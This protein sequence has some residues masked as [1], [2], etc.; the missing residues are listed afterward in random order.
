M[1]H[2]FFFNDNPVWS[3]GVGELFESPEASAATLQRTY[4][5]IAR[6]KPGS[7]LVGIFASRSG[8]HVAQS[9]FAVDSPDTSITYL[10]YFPHPK[11]GVLV[12]SWYPPTSLYMYINIDTNAKALATTHTDIIM[13]LIRITIQ[14]VIVIRVLIY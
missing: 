8:S 1:Y 13:R 5:D 12:F 14:I 3:A 9:N 10:R 11:I 7:Y 2:S 4:A 6:G